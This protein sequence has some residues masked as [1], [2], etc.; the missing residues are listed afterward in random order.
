M[1][2]STDDQGDPQHIR[3]IKK[4]AVYDARRKFI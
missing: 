2:N 3:I 4:G 1:I